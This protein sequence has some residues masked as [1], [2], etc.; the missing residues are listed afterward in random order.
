MKYSEKIIKGIDNGSIDTDDLKTDF[1]EYLYKK[2]YDFED[3][4][5]FSDEHFQNLL[6]FKE[7][8]KIFKEFT[9]R[10]NK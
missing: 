1:N 7:N 8:E 3:V 2:G 10:N 9:N 4:I 5:N 6:T